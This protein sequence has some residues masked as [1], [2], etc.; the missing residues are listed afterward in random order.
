MGSRGTKRIGGGPIGVGAKTVDGDEVNFSCCERESG[1]HTDLPTN[2][3]L[4]Y[5]YIN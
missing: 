2:Y 3:W 4:L 5:N 1:S